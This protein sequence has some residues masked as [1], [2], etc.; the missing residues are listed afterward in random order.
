MTAQAVLYPA[1]LALLTLLV[2][3]TVPRQ[4]LRSLIPYG[5]V[6]GGLFDFLY[7]LLLGNIFKIISFHNAGLFDASGH[8]F[9]APLAW[10]LI[11]VIYLYFWPQG[12]HGWGWTYGFTWA[13][14]ATGFSQIVY[15]VDLFHFSPWFYPLPMFISFA[16]RFALATWIT[17]PWSADW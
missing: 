5:V 8:V 16:V 11:M 1:L 17:K 6:L 3:I 2:L 4:A 15:A 10:A 7:N 12:H 14:L 13:L 9:L